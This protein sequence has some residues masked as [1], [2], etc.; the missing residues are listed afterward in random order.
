MTT[1]AHHV[2]VSFRLPKDLADRLEEK[3]RDNDRT[4]SAELRVA[5]RAYYKDPELQRLYVP[6]P[7]RA[8]TPRV[9]SHAPQIQ[10]RMDRCPIC[11]NMV[12]M[13]REGVLVPHASTGG[14]AQGIR[15]CPGGSKQSGRYYYEVEEVPCETQA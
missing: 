7:A 12:P 4:V 13:G 3:A 15:W 2:S 11:T 9:P 6:K 14:P 1:E 10:R 5:L 8:K